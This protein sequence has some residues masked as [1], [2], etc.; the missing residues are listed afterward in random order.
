[1]G[2][3]SVGW[4]AGRQE[5]SLVG[6]AV[7]RPCSLAGWLIAYLISRVPKPGLF[8]AVSLGSLLRF[9]LPYP[10]ALIELCRN[11]EFAKKVHANLVGR[12]VEALKSLELESNGA[13]GRAPI[14]S[15]EKWRCVLLGN[16]TVDILRASPVDTDSFNT[17]LLEELMKANVDSKEM[18]ISFY[19]KKVLQ[20]LRSK[21]KTPGDR[22]QSKVS[23]DSNVSS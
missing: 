6:S 14:D 3:R 19:R 11:P 1:M 22:P 20:L 13:T 7:G 17:E 4:L 18:T 23:L 15:R 9:Q 16:L 12:F 2:R 21:R 8:Q 10:D 5:G